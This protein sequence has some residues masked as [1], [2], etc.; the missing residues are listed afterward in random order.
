MLASFSKLAEKSCG[1]GLQLAAELL[2]SPNAFHAFRGRAPPQI[3]TSAPP[4]TPLKEFP[5]ELELELPGGAGAARVVAAF[6]RG[7]E[8]GV[9]SLGANTWS[10]RSD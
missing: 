6:S 9:W 10:R 8:T 4:G 2:S 7:L 1:T 3:R 5:E